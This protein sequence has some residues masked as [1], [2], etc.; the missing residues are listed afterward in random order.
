MGEMNVN[1]CC[2]ERGEARRKKVIPKKTQIHDIQLISTW[3]RHEQRFSPTR[4]SKGKPRDGVGGPAEGPHPQGASQVVG[5]M[6]GWATAVG[7]MRRGG[8][9]GKCF[10]VEI[11]GYFS[12][13]LT[14]LGT[15]EI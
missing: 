8:K 4:K 5:G 12:P 7:H 15:S 2:E 3:D 6:W 1:L 13:W 11:V 10:E 14:M 9:E